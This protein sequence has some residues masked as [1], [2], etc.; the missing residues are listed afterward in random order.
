MI[1]IGRT[2]GSAGNDIGFALA[3][4]L[5]INYY[6]AEI[7]NQVMKRLEAD[8]DSVNDKASFTN[9]DKYKKKSGFHLKEWIRDFN[10]YH[11]LPTQD[12][13]FFNMSDLICSMARS[14][15]ALLWDDVQMRF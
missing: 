1:C 13:V 11:G 14:G 7:F 10:R 2:Q 5:R 3:D 4:A 12:A 6:D 8:K 9:F 15:T